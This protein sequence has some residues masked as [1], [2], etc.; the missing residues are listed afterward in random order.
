[1][2]DVEASRARSSTA[3]AA[4]TVC[5]APLQIAFSGVERGLGDDLLLEQLMLAIVG[6]LRQF[7]LRLGL[8]GAGRRLVD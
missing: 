5:L 3:C 8:L 1:M 2:S 6:L 7:Q 4:A